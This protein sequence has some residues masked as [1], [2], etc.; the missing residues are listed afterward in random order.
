MLAVLLEI[1]FAHNRTAFHR[2]MV[3]RAGNLVGLAGRTDGRTECDV[4]SI[5]RAQWV[6]VETHL[7][8]DPSG[9][10]SPISQCQPQR[11]IRHAW[12]HP[13]RSADGLIAQLD[14]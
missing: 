5:G 9:L 6:Y 3:L 4:F 1:G 14:L 2:P 12:L 10:L 13:D 7:M 11:I 8:T